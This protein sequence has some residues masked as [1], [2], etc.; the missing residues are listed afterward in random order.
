MELAPSV[1]TPSTKASGAPFKPKRQPPFVIPT[2]VLMGLQ[3]T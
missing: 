1:A 2:E 3:P